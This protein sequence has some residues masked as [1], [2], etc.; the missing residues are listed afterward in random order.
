MDRAGKTRAA[1]F[2]TKISAIVLAVNKTFWTIKRR[3]HLF[4]ALSGQ[5]NDSPLEIFCLERL[6]APSSRHKPVPASRRRMKSA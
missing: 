1:F 6:R 5:M 2:S 3:F 4:L